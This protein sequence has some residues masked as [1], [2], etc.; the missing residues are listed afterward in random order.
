MI[1]YEHSLQFSEQKSTPM[2]FREEKTVTRGEGAGSYKGSPPPYKPGVIDPF[3]DLLIAQIL[4]RKI[5][6]QKLN[7]KGGG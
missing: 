5:L 6:R 1:I 7:A 4:S 2:W 3:F